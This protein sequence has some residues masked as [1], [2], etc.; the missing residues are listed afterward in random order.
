MTSHIEREAR[1]GFL[2]ATGQWPQA[3]QFAGFVAYGLNRCKE[4]SCTQHVS[5]AT[6]LV[7]YSYR[8]FYER[9]ASM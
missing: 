5:Y 3:R 9:A 2:C 6:L 4:V 7:F 8:Y 1:L